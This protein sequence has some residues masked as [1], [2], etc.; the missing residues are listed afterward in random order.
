MDIDYNKLTDTQRSFVNS[1]ARI[2]ERL[3]TLQKQM[4]IIQHEAKGLIEEL[5]ELRNKENKNKENG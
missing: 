2:N 3:T 1:Y 5:E 4:T